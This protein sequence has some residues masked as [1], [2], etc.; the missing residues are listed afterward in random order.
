MSTPP[1]STAR[2]VFIAI[3]CGASS[4]RVMAV[5]WQDAGLSIHEV[6]RFPT[7]FYERNGGLHWDLQVMRDEFLTGLREAGNRYGQDVRSIGADTWGVDYVLLDAAGEPM[8]DPFQ[9]RDSRT[10]GI[11]PWMDERVSA[12]ERF[13]RTGI[14]NQFFN[15]ANQLCADLHLGNRL[16]A[17]ADCLLYMP[18]WINY[19][20]CGVK[21][22]ELTEASTAQLLDQDRKYHQG[23]LEE[24]GIPAG[25]F[26]PLVEP[27]TVLAPLKDDLQQDLGISPQVVTVASHDT[28]SAYVAAPCMD[29]RTA[30]LSSGTWS[31]FGVEANKLEVSETAYKYGLT[32]EAGVEGTTRLL[33]N[34][35]GLWMIQECVREWRAQ[36]ETVDFGELD[37]A[38]AR[39]PGWRILLNP[40]H[41][42]FLV[43]G[44]M[45]EKIR[46]F[47]R[48]TGQPIPN[49][50]GAIVRA[51]QDTL[52]LTYRRT[53]VALRE[54][55][56][57]QLERINIVGGGAQSRLLN[58]LTADATECEVLAGPIEATALGNAI[59]QM[60]A[61]GLIENMAEG[62]KLIQAS[63]PL[64]TYSPRPV[65]DREALLSRFEDVCQ[66]LA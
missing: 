10:D 42:P 46:N 43:P 11:I 61:L 59:M 53:L 40:D 27:G 34:I 50:K 15:T 36:G 13:A 8:D 29:E 21:R 39:E 4:S 64:E 18:D 6:H 5:I 31:L 3:D 2:Q 22:N 30:F 63:F 28:G 19:L 7:P 55:T 35:V 16:V 1:P 24:Y 54:L 60:K 14:Q 17:K 25:V 56:G 44:D 26:A 48:R 32:N 57:L 66:P 51:I 20:L 49:T 47:C 62:R 37:K 52:A 9:Y 33:R 58:Q 23:L 12:W 65:P 38:S 45:P 41:G